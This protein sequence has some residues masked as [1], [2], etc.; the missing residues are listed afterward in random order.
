[1][2]VENREE[3]LRDLNVTPERL[4]T[5]TAVTLKWLAARLGIGRWTYEANNLYQHRAHR[6]RPCKECQ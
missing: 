6:T 2:T 1:M 4:R 5:E 3:K